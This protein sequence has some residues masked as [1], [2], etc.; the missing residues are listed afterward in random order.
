MKEIKSFREY[1][2]EHK[3]FEDENPPVENNSKAPVVSNKLNVVDAQLKLTKRDPFER[4]KELK[5]KAELTRKTY[6]NLDKFVN[7]EFS[8]RS[9]SNN[10]DAMFNITNKTSFKTI[11]DDK[12]HFPS[13][14]SF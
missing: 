2:A 8:E 4:L 6:E 10:P 7:G 9:D 11:F 1:I 13:F 12:P 5:D 3:L 14:E